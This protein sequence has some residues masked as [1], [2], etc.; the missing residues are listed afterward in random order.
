VGS[1]V[2][3]LKGN[4]YGVSQMGGAN[5]Y[6]AIYKIDSARNLTVLYSFTGTEG[7]NPE[8]GITIDQAGNLYG[9]TPFGGNS[10]CWNGCGTL[11]KLD[12]SG[13]FTVLHYFT[14]GADGNL[15]QSGVVLDKAGNLYGTT[16]VGGGS[17]C[18][19]GSG[20][21]CGVVYKYGTSGN[22]TV[23]HSFTGGPDG[24][25]PVGSP[26]WGPSGAL[27][28]TAAYY[29]DS[30]GDGTIFKIDAAGKFSVVHAFNGDDGSIPM[31]GLIRDSAGNLYGTTE[32]G[33][34]YGLGTVFKLAP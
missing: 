8:A 14:G 16:S 17:S 15:P 26:I 10:A 5:S 13:N 30:I 9:T 22:F 12:A 2:T 6:G 31:S 32:Q 33:G 24:G 7:Q 11:F 28:G 20:T 18:V 23:L 21:G 34:T 4:F 27:Y 19:T 25:Y 1:L 29:G 3:D